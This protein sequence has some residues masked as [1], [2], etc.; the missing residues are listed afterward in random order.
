MKKD[1]V[2]KTL[3]V[4][5]VFVVITSFFQLSFGASGERDSSCNVL[6]ISEKCPL[7]GIGHLVYGDLTIGG[8]LALFFHYLAH[9]SQVRLDKIISTNAVSYTHLTLPTILLV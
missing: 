3:L 6:E 5:V 8:V 7:S 1:L 2:L 4:F 9:K